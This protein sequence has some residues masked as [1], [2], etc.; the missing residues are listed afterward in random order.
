MSHKA[1]R[2][3]KRALV[4]WIGVVIVVAGILWFFHQELIDWYEMPGTYPI[5]KHPVQ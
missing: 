5:A 1:G 2:F 3:S 4:V